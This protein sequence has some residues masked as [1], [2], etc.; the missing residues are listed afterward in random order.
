MY[1]VSY[2]CTFIDGPTSFRVA[3]ALQM[4][5]AIL[6]F[7]FLMFLPE[8]PRWLASKGRWE[9]AHFVIANVNAKGN[10]QNPLVLAEFDEVK[11]AVRIADESA[12]LSIFSLFSPYMWK[13]TFIGCSAQM[14][15]QLVLCTVEFTHIRLE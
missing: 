15:Q 11:E 8:S 5:P 13:R 4:I 1:Y 3:W 12:R 10:L 2:A 14:W 6:L 7:I 9:D